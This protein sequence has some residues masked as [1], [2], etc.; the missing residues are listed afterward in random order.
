MKKP[1]GPSALKRKSERIPAKPKKPAKKSLS[2]RKTI[3]TPQNTL[4]SKQLKSRSDSNTPRVSTPE[5]TVRD[6][7]KTEQQEQDSWLG[8][9]LNT[10]MDAIITMDE[11]EQIVLFNKGAEEIFRCTSSRCHREIDR[12]VHSPAVSNNSSSACPTIQTIGR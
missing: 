10:A 4:I 11:A 6:Q 7:L 1:R 3:G 9:V 2:P 5:V 12:P 8:I